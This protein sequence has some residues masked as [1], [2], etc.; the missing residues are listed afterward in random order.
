MHGKRFRV[1][2]RN[3]ENMFVFVLHF[4]LN[5]LLFLH[6]TKS[7]AEPVFNHYVQ[8]TIIQFILNFYEY[9][10][11]R[12]IMN[13]EEIDDVTRGAMLTLPNFGDK[14]LRGYFISMGYKMQRKSCAIQ[15]R[16]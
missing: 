10:L 9:V 14:S 4:T 6:N 1:F 13:D 2:Q 8:R 3:F 5:L 11:L 15:L 16:E 7:R 12:S